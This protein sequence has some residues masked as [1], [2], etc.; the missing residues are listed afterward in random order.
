M[1]EACAI[2]GRT[3]VD[4]NDREQTELL[5][6]IWNEMKALGQNLGG[7]IDALGGRIDQTNER[8][9]VMRVE[10]K[11]ELDTMR[12][13][14]KGEIAQTNVRLGSVEEHLRDLAAQ[15]LMLG[16]FVKN[17]MGRRDDAIDDLRERVTRIEA[18]LDPK[19]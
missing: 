7:R 15:Q 10:L 13:E 19:G 16:R 1:H 12:V 3:H 6:N 2:L 14:L 9:D 11:G 4:P 8:L 17:T 18:R 5:R